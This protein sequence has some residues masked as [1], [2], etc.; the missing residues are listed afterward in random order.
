MM[1]RKIVRYAEIVMEIGWLLALVSIPL[2]FNIYTSRVFEPDK[3]TLFRTLVLIMALAWAVKGLAYLAMEKTVAPQPQTASMRKRATGATGQPE[4]LYPPDGEVVGPDNRPFPQNFLRRPLVIPALIISFAYVI[5]TLFSVVPGVSWWGSY[6]RL[7]GTYT[8]L[9]YVTFFMVIIFNMRERRQLERLINFVL[10]ANIPIALYGILQHNGGDPLPW[11]GDVK[12]RITST[13]GN[14]IFISAYLIMVVPLILYRGYTTLVWLWE[15]RAVSYKYMSGRNRDAALSWIALYSI[16]IVFTIG[17]FLAVMNYNATYRPEASTGVARASEVARLA[18]DTA[19][20]NA[21]TTVG[22]EA[23]GPW[24]ALPL[25]IVI[26]FSLFFL[27]SIRRQGTENNYLFRVFEFAGYAA[28][29]V[30]VLLAILYSQS[31]GPLSGLLV[32][33]FFFF[34][35][36]FW[37]RKYKKLLIGWLGFGLIAGAVLFMFNLPPGSTP[38]E[39]VFSVARQN[40]QIARL[41]QFFETQDGTGRVRFL[42]WKTVLEAVDNSLKRDQLHFIFGYGPEALYNVS[43]RFYQPELAQLEARNAIPDRSHNGYLDALVTTGVVGILAYATLVITFFVYAFKF[44]KRTE[45]LD[46]QILITALGT[47]VVAHIVEVI[48]GIQ[49]VTSWMMFFTACALLVVAGGLVSGR[50]D[51]TGAKANAA[52]S[53]EESLPEETEE[54]TK[55][56]PEPAL[57]ASAGAATAANVNM[58]ATKNGGGGKKSKNRNRNLNAPLAE[59]TPPKDVLT[60]I[61]ADKPK[62]NERNRRT[63]PAIANGNDDYFAY[64]VPDRPVR[65]WIWGAA[66]ALGV[67][68][69]AYTWFGNVSPILADSVYK[70]GFNLVQGAPS[71]DRAANLFKQSTELAPNEDYYALYLG[72]AYLELGKQR[73]RD[74]VNQ[75]TGQQDAQKITV[76]R[77][78]LNLSEK[79]LLRA[80]RL[81]P[82]NPDHYA[83]M[84][85]L[86]SSWADIEPTRSQELLAKSVKWYEDVTSQHAPRNARL[87]SE[88]ALTAATLASNRVDPDISN[89]ATDPAYMN[90]AVAAAEQSVKLDD[91]YNFNRL[92]LGDVYRFAKRLPEAGEQYA[93]LAEIAPRDLASDAR[94]ARRV[95]LIAQSPQVDT[96]KIL[97]LFDPEKPPKPGELANANDKAF[98][99]LGRGMIQFYKN[100]LTNAGASLTNAAQLNPN[101]PYAPAFQSVIAKRQGQATQSQNFA[102]TA[103][104]LAAKS[105]TTVP[106]IQQAI[107]TI[108]TTN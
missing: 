99:A 42:I 95:Q 4:V 87:W 26:C 44:L 49:I 67:L 16:F 103:R 40:P 45:R 12:N 17:V 54:V 15:N 78:Y 18:G 108:L 58:A 50:W 85:R 41:G 80:N 27:F 25:G 105:A 33:L 47:A 20:A 102:T 11:Q 100:D 81:A 3:I 98:F 66:T 107:E 74:A 19:G 34:P 93:K 65:P 71:W 86:Y 24:W 57:V 8:F 28:L 2:Y 5:S 48:T 60:T 55:I 14:A 30:I 72:Q 104:D 37:R 63:G 36:I 31:R 83:N 69:L 29:G 38:L 13:M 52:P 68:M 9:S 96:N 70:Q 75:Q 94:F 46:Y 91:R 61:R 10:L 101:D 73:F 64:S 76:G 88:Q 77:N 97:A 23:I 21:N 90:K 43:P 39:P 106:G 82:L 22:S 62:A 6:Q 56:T 32:G 92:V 79:E 51:A 53:T 1:L 84:A 59:K 89:T 7:Q 35:I